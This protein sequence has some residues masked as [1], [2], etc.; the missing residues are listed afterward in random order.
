MISLYR[1]PEGKN[2]FTTENPTSQTDNQKKDSLGANMALSVLGNDPKATIATLQAK[3]QNLE[4]ELKK[5]EVFIIIL[6]Y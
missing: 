1:D 3:I 2:I 4:G 5:Y 6:R